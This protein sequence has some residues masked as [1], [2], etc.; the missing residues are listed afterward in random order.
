[1]TFLR[2]EDQTPVAIADIAENI[3]VKFWS[4]YCFVSFIFWLRKKAED[5]LN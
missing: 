5:I 1:L 4:R 2:Q 3:S